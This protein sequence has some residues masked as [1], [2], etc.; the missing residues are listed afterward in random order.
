MKE[1]AEMQ[2]EEE[3]EEEEETEREI[4]QFKKEIIKRQKAS[5]S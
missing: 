3:E 1:E 2:K 4:I 5:L